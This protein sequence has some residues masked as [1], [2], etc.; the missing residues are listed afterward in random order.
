M[1]D[2]NLHSSELALSGSDGAIVV[3][4]EK[5]EVFVPSMDDEPPEDGS[6]DPLNTVNT[7]AFLMYALDRPDW[8]QEFADEIEGAYEEYKEEIQKDK[9]KTLGLTVIDGGKCS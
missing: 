1:I 3:R 5:I 4:P 9:V 7:I 2:I 6:T 8:F